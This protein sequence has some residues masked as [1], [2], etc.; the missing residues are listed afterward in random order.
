ML[1]LDQKQTSDL[2]LSLVKNSASDIDKAIEGASFGFQGCYTICV[3]KART[4]D[5]DIIYTYGLGIPELSS[6]S[7]NVN[8][9]AEASTMKFTGIILTQEELKK[10]H[11]Y[12]VVK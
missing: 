7:K 1:F 5:G 2:A 11:K 9:E 3:G 4:R 6:Q 10:A 12:P 8:I